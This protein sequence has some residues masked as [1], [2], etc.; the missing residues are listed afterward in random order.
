MATFNGERFLAEQ[1]DSLQKQTVTSWRLYVSDDGSTDGTMDIIKRYQAMWGADKIQYRQ[2]PQTGL[3]QNFLSL[4]CDPDI[5]SD[6][7]AFCDQDDVWLP[8]KLSVAMLHISQS[9]TQDQVYAYSSRTTYTDEKLEPTGMSPLFVFP[10]TFRNALIQSIAGGNTMVFN[11][12]TKMLLEKVGMVPAPSHDW[13]LYQLV[14]G[15]GGEMYY[16][17]ESRILYRQ[18]EKSIV[19]RNDSLKALII[20]LW[21]IMSNKYSKYI[22][23]NIQSLRLSELYLIKSNK[24]ILEIF[25]IMRKAKLKDRIRL[26]EICGLYRQTWRGTISLIIASILKKI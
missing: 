7:F 2:G 19:G 4:A 6:Y 16:D 23:L 8:D 12:A 11:Q 17:P 10:R 26:L 9:S 1:L 21:K 24:E 14:T 5:K 15:V 3:A 22:D 13:W 25:E 18:H 20:R